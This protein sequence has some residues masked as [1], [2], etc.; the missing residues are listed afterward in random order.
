MK[1]IL[2]ILAITFALIIGVVIYGLHTYGEVKEIV[3][4]LKDN[5]IQQDMEALMSGDCS[6]LASI[7][8]QYADIEEDIVRAC[9]N[10]LVKFALARGWVEDANV[11]KICAEIGNPNNE[12]EKVLNNIKIACANN[13]VSSQ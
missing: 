8:S 5:S 11:N 10:Q 13:N 2:V 9:D 7:E 6:K 3:L 12:I 1:I 4:I